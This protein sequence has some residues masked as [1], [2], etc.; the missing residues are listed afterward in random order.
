MSEKLPS[1]KPR[2]V[3]RALMKAGFEGRV[4]RP[5]TRRE[6]L[7]RGLAATSGLLLGGCAP[8]VVRMTDGRTASHP[9]SLG[10]RGNVLLGLY[11]RETHVD[12]VAAVR[13]A[14]G[15]L[16]WS[17]LGRGDSV[18]VKLSC[19]SAYPHPAA[20]SPHAVRA[21]VAELRERGAGRILVGDQA[22]AGYVRLAAGERRFSSTREQAATNGLLAAIEESG[23]T[24]HFFDDQGY[25]RGYFQAELPFDRPAWREPPHLARVIRE[26]DHVV[27]LPRLSSH[28][29]AGHTH[30]HKLAVGWL[31]D[32]SRFQFHYEAATFHEKFVE[33]NYARELCDRRRLVLTFA[34]QAL[35]TVG[36]HRGSVAR[37]DSWIVITS[38]DLA[39]HDLAATAMLTWLDRVTPPSGLHV[40]PPPYGIATNL[41]NWLYLSSMVPRQ[42][43][44]PWGRPDSW[45]YQPLAVQRYREG[46][47]CDRVLTHAY[48]LGGGRPSRV[49]VRIAGSEPAAG[50]RSFLGTW[51]GGVLHV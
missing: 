36:P 29:L 9:D 43:G 14:C 39:N 35:L 50:L 33:I 11:S 30:G 28:V 6:L 20:T 37:P 7:A 15:C 10:R 34:E 26:V 49:D 1:V 32:D 21:L 46:L 5:P 41:C 8:R 12:P 27:Y 17:W 31:R 19:N 44:I 2:E 47:A 38:A 23:A 25:T 18:F 3:A 16:D 51:S 4:T 48:R 40:V 45:H 24:P 13:E 22:G 42:T